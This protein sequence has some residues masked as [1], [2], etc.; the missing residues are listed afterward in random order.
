MDEEKIR[1]RDWLMYPFGGRIV[2]QKREFKQFMKRV[3]DLPQ[4]YAFVYKK[5]MN[6]A[7]MFTSGSG[8]DRLPVLTDLLEMFE[9]AAA[10]D[11]KVLE[12]TGDDVAGFCDELFSQCKTFIQDWR[13]KLNS[14]IANKL[15]GG[16]GE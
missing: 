12:V 9:R 10:D 11:K 5:I 7:W 16:D 6:H 8:M 4:E 13:Q 14:E 1:I 2:K 3:D 15:K